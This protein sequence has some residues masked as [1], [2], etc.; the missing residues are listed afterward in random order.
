M[1][2]KKILTAVLSVLTFVVGGVA[3]YFAFKVGK[4]PQIEELP[5]TGMTCSCTSYA[6]FCGGEKCTFSGVPADYCSVG[7]IASCYQPN[8][9]RCA[10]YKAE[11]RCSCGNGPEKPGY[12]IVNC[13]QVHDK[14]ERYTTLCEACNNPYFCKACYVKITP[15]PS[16]S[17]SPKPSLSPSP[18]PSVSPSP[19]P[20]ASPSPSLSVSP[21]P[22]PTATI[23]PT[24]LIND[25]VDR[26]IIGFALL[27][28]G[29]ISIKFGLHIKF[30]ELFWNQKSLGTMKKERD[31]FE[32]GFN[33][34]L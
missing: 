9:V 23:V 21:S 22:S 19:S 25:D 13:S 33:K 6:T 10:G 4:E 14:E 32:K 28:F 12:K 34:E 17:P 26:I 1:N 3:I 24:A 2:K 11:C 27:T 30:G 8:D 15:T 5:Q 7:S 31:E 29:F 16:P 18:K 20:S